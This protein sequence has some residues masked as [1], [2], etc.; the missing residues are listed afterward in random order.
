MECALCLTDGLFLSVCLILG[1]C[2]HLGQGCGIIGS[3]FPLL[4]DF[5]QPPEL[6]LLKGIL[7]MI[8]RLLHLFRG[9]GLM[10]GGTGGRNLGLGEGFCPNSLPFQ[11]EL[12]CHV[13]LFRLH[14]LR[15]IKGGLFPG[16]ALLCGSEGF[17]ALGDLRSVLTQGLQVLGGQLTAPFLHPAPGVRNTFQQGGTG[18]RS[19]G[20]GNLPI[21]LFRGGGGFINRL[22]CLFCVC[23]LHIWDQP[24]GFIRPCR[25]HLQL[26]VLELQPILQHLL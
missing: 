5:T 20:G 9:N 3:G 18:I 14:P 12:L 1:V 24:P 11:P 8:N 23:F 25:D 21:Q 22:P 16:K 17:F 13:G 6:V 26:G 2:H 10:T 7:G 15:F 19:H 4:G